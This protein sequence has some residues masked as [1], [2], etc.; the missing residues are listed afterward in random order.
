MDAFEK[1]PD[2]DA[3]VFAAA[4]NVTAVARDV[5]ASHPSA[6]S[7]VDSYPASVGCRYAEERI[8][9]VGRD[10]DQRLPVGASGQ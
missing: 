2:N 10:Q 4:D 1:I 3:E 7:F 6:V 8:N 9:R 5:D